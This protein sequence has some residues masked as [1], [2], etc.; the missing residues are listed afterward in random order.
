MECPCPFKQFKAMS[1]KH[2][3]WESLKFPSPCWNGEGNPD[4][5]ATGYTGFPC[6]SALHWAMKAVDFSHLSLFLE[7]ESVA[8][9]KGE[10]NQHTRTRVADPWSNSTEILRTDLQVGL[11]DLHPSASL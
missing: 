1:I 8:D 10:Q 7:S 2:G 6:S 11:H 9:F 4:P 5:R 3:R